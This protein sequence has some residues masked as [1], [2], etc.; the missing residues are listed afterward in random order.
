MTVLRNLRYG[1]RILARNPTFGAAAVT[2]MA[3]GIG[4]TTAVFSVVRGVLLQPLPYRQPER[5]VLFRANGPGIVREALVTG[6][7]LAAVR[8]RTD[9]FESVAVINESPTSLT[10]PD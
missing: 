10:T 6:D 8:T 9:L 4:A 5:L 7:E 3:L 1:L 2:V